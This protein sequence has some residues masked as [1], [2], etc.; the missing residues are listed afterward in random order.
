MCQLRCESSWHVVLS[1]V[2][3]TKAVRAGAAKHTVFE[4][5]GGTK[6]VRE[7]ELLRALVAAYTDGEN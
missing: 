2:P 5:E 3:K 7:H 4:C 1:P 6:V